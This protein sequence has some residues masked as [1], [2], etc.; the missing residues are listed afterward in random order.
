MLKFLR[1]DIKNLIMISRLKREMIH[2]TQFEGSYMHYLSTAITTSKITSAERARMR[3]ASVFVCFCFYEW[4]TLRPRFEYIQGSPMRKDTL[5]GCV[6][7]TGGWRDSC[8]WLVEM[9]LVLNWVIC[10]HHVALSVLWMT[11]KMGLRDEA[12]SPI[13]PFSLGLSLLSPLVLLIKWR[14]NL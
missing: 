5:K 3:D 12:L 14:G 1:K 13:S 4:E 10:I 8:Q 9:C 6:T 7:A 11:A 2:A